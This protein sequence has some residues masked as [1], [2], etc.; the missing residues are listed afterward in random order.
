MV[1]K[2]SKRNG[3]RILYAFLLVLAALTLLALALLNPRQEELQIQSGDVSLGATLT[4]PRFG[5]RHPVVIILHGS[6]DDGRDNRYYSYLVR[7]L[8]IS[9]VAV[10]LYDK[11][12]CGA[13]G[14]D[15]RSSPFRSLT[16]D[17]LAA[18]EA[19]KLHPGID[20]ACIG[21]WGCSEGGA[22]AVWAASESPDVSFLVMQSTPGV[23]FS[24]QNLFQTQTASL[25]AGLTGED[26]ERRLGLQRL[27]HDVARSGRGWEEYSAR[28]EQS[29][30]EAWRADI[31]GTL[32][33]DDY[34]W[35]WYGSKLDFNPADKLALVKVPVRAV[36]G[37]NDNLVPVGESENA[38]QQAAARADNLRFVSKVY[39]HADHSLLTPE[40]H[41]PQLW[42]TAKWIRTCCSGSR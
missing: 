14:G 26:L 18:I 5:G 29:Q 15:W 38:L 17:A 2:Q 24:Q 40:G 42:E 33:R 8:T 27:M 3:L 4:L 16:D 37:E 10:L 12:G 34:W 9:G 32:A 25:A 41:M 11:R 23:S 19:M 28:L 36:W 39:P 31:S 35:S 21:L 6:G 1:K 13:S 22:V 20:P 7:A 30:G